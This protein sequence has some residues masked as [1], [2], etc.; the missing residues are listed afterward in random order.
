MNILALVEYT[1]ILPQL[2]PG[3][4]EIFTIQCFMCRGPISPDGKQSRKGERQPLK[5][6]S[7]SFYSSSPSSTL[8]SPTFHEK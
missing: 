4:L 6:S 3:G 7:C 1:N 2:L 8:I 5:M